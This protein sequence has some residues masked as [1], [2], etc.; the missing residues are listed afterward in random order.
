[1]CLAC[2]SKL[3]TLTQDEFSAEFVAML[4]HASTAL[5]V[6]I[7]HR[8]GLFKAMRQIPASNSREIADAAGLNERYV[9]EW[10]GALAAA[11]FVEVDPS[12]TWFHL[13]PVQSSALGTPG[14][15]D[16]LAHLAQYIGMIGGVEDRLVYCFRHG[17]GISYDEYPR[18]HDIMAEESTQS[19]VSSLTDHILPLVPG[20]TM[21][22][23]IGID[24][25]DIG[26]GRGFAIM[27]LAKQ[28]PSSRFV[29]YDLSREAIDY[30]NNEAKR[31]KLD[32]VTFE[33]RDLSNFHMDALPEAFD[34]VTAFD[35]I[36]DQARPDHVLAGIRRSLK[37]DGTF[38]MQDIGASSNIAENVEHPLG[39]LLYTMSCAHC[40]SVSLAQGGLGLGAMWGEQMTTTYLKNAGFSSVERNTLPHDI[41]NYYYVV[42]A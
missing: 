28:F 16:C 8:T 13:N 6:S 36:H 29:G 31:R 15:S 1:M 22:L 26:C 18:F 4:N 20:M 9:R 34:L 12:G 3:S 37:P 25:L 41:Q 39:P 32:N 5:M 11:G 42:R 24:V 7:G 40:M 30:A 38:L 10:L 17:G 14:T 2:N 23:S 21:A 27:E 19:V 35:A 33:I